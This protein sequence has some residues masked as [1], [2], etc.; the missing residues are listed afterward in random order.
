MWAVTKESLSAIAVPAKQSI[1]IFGI[2][3]SN[4]MAEKMSPGM[5]LKFFAMRA[6]STMNM[7]NGEKFRNGFSAACAF[8]SICFE[9]FWDK[10]FS[11]RTFIFQSLIGMIL[12][13]FISYCVIFSLLHFPTFIASVISGSGPISRPIFRSKF[14]I[15]NTA[16][17]H[18][19]HFSIDKMQ[20][21]N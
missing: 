6:A 3:R 18:A 13:P 10:F 9:N 4:D 20:L 19:D 11:R 8:I 7:V 12:H 15:A 14:N 17:F 1:E 16:F 21:A 2:S 5:T